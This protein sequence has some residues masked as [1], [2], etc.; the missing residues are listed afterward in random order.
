MRMPCPWA[1]I[2]KNNRQQ[3][4]RQQFAGTIEMAGQMRAPSE[5]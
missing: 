5:A 2:K 3:D 1:G 4:P